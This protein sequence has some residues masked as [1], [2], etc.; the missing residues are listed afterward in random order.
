[1]NLN[2]NKF[3]SKMFKLLR[4]FHAYIVYIGFKWE[5]LRNLHLKA[6]GSVL[7]HIIKLKYNAKHFEEISDFYDS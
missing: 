4:S 6:R 5:L 2:L 3:Y 7:G 1:M